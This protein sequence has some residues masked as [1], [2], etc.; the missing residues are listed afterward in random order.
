[1]FGPPIARACA[2]RASDDWIH[3]SETAEG[4]DISVDTADAGTLRGTLNLKGPT[5]EADI[6][7]DVEL[8][9]PQ[10]L[11]ATAE[12]PS[13]TEE[14]ARKE[15]AETARQQAEE[16]EEKALQEAAEA[17]QR[18]AGEKARQDA[19][20][21]ARRQA[22]EQA[23]QD[24]TE[25]A[26]RDAGEQARQEIPEA[27]STAP[28][29]IQ[30][31]AAFAGSGL[32]L[33]ASITGLIS[34]NFWPGGH[35][36][37]LFAIAAYLMAVGA[38]IAVLLRT[39]QL[40]TVGFLQGLCWPA[41]AYLVAD[42]LNAAVNN[43]FYLTGRPLGGFYLNLI[44]DVLFVSAAILLMISWRSAMSGRRAAGLRPLPVVLLGAVGLSQVAGLFLWAHG[45]T[46][47]YGTNYV[48]GIAA[49]LVGLQ[50]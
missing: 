36:H 13:Q 4:L 42:I 2:P 33:L 18:Q 34:L 11:Q 32:A 19:A 24:A 15:A 48:L 9:P 26:E 5:G 44:T 49:L 1:L 41:A 25:A 39:D 16:A 43:T 20:E 12:T 27:P 31:G 3:V 40:A 28:P 50:V 7:I 22:G 14:K 47:I 17:A 37:L 8:L 6:A 29:H 46:P 21:A 30:R 23:R 45:S 38:A 10:P 35:T